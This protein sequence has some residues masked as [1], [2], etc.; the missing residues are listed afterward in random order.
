MNINEFLEILNFRIVSA[1]P[2]GEPIV[3]S[4][5]DCI[6]SSVQLSTGGHTEKATGSSL[7]QEG[8]IE[9]LVKKMSCK[10]LILDGKIP[11]YISVPKLT[12]GDW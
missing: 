10:L 11:R 8:A 4:L 2:E 12:Y 9:D 6:G 3:V 7:S 5:E 1:A